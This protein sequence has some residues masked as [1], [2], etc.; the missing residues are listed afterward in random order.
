MRWAWI[1]LLCC[2]IGCAT[3][4]KI[5]C[6]T[7]RL[8]DIEFDEKLVSDPSMKPEVVRQLKE[9]MRVV[10]TRDGKYAVKL[11]EGTET[12]TW[13]YDKKSRTIIT[14]TSHSGATTT[15][16]SITAHRLQLEV[17]DQ[18]GIQM[19]MTLIPEK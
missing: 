2:S 12:G 14:R 7:W 19:K 16:R 5:L 17:N 11:P 18:N 10:F 9:S 8:E 1:T 4:Q 13:C 6:G 3:P 15:L